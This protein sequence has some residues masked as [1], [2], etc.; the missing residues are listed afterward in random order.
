MPDRLNRGLAS[1]LL[2]WIEWV[3]TEV[4][5]FPELLEAKGW[6]GRSIANR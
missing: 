4:V 6:L 5:G 1:L 3:E 2:T